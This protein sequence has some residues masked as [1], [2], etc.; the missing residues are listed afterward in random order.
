VHPVDAAAV[1]R[2]DQNTLQLTKAPQFPRAMLKAQHL[3][4]AA[5]P[6][7]SSKAAFATMRTT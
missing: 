4:S 6:T 3:G 2:A 1:A 7:L 5:C